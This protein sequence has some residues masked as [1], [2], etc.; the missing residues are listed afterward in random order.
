MTARSS[1][2]I[3]HEIAQRLLF[4]Q[5]YP[6]ALCQVEAATYH[7]ETRQLVTEYGDALVAERAREQRAERIAPVLGRMLLASLAA[8]EAAREADIVQI[9]APDA[10]LRRTG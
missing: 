1:T 10:P 7:H 4:A 5:E 3:A 8:E 2:A 6:A 9:S